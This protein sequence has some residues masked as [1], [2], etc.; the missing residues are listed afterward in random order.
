LPEPP[1]AAAQDFEATSFLETLQGFRKASR[2]AKKIPAS[3][4]I[5]TA[6]ELDVLLSRVAVDNSPEAWA[7]LFL[8]PHIAFDVLSPNSNPKKSLTSKLKRNLRSWREGTRKPQ[9]PKRLPPKS[10]NAAKL[11]QSNDARLARQVEGKMA[12]GDIR[13]AVRILSSSEGLAPFTQETFTALKTKHPPATT[14]MPPPSAPDIP[15]LQ[16][17]E[18]EVARTVA[19]FPAGSSGGPDGLRPQ[20]LK[21]LLSQNTGAAGTKLL[22]SLTEVTN[23]ILAGGVP[24]QVLPF[25]F[26]ANLVALEKKGGGIRPIAM[27]CTLRKLAAKIACESVRDHLGSQ[28]QPLQMGF[29]TTCGAE[30]SVHASRRFLSTCKSGLFLKLDFANAFNS[31]HR[32]RVLEATHQHLPSLFPLIQQ[33]Y[34]APSTLFFGQETLQSAEGLQQGDPLGSALFCLTIHDL[35]KS[36][37][38]HLNIWYADDGTLGG[39]GRFVLADLKTIQDASAELGLHLNPAKCELW[40]IG[41]DEQ[42]VVDSISELLPGI[43]IRAL[44]DC[45]LL[46]APLT[47]EAIPSAFMEKIEE[48]KRLTSRLPSLQAHSA[49]FLLKN[50]FSIPKLVYIL[51][52]CPSWKVQHLLNEFDKVTRSAL[53]IITNVSISD[54]TWAQ[55]SLPVSRGGLGIRSA[56]DL[57]VPAFLASI[58]STAY[59]VPSILSRTSHCPDPDHEEALWIWHRLT[60]YALIPNSNQQRDWEAPVLDRLT[61]SLL[62]AA[63]NPQ[64]KARLLATGRKESGAWLSALPCA[65]LGLALDNN[66]VRI[67]VGLRLGTSLCHPHKCVCGEPVD[68]LGTH[69]LSCIKKGGTF[70]RHFALN[71]IIQRA[72][73]K[74]HVPTLLEPTNMFRTDGKRADGLTLTPW[75]RGK[76]L[77]WDATCVDTLCKSYVPATAKNSGAAAARAEKKKTDLYAQLPSQYQFVP[78]AVETLGPIGEAAQKFIRELGGRLRATTGEP[79]ETTWL[80]QRISLAIQ[81]GNAASVLATIPPNSDYYQTYNL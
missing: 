51:R 41:V 10:K 60:D 6:T 64:E 66:A 49:L 79:R 17:D 58:A 70:S 39:P 44:E 67:A 62:E 23:L 69:G 1:P 2:I 8:F 65:P 63:Q 19:H 38:S 61:A 72:C 68:G 77:V 42:V 37:K 76:S 29:G 32:S 24:K 35:V 78:F 75:S 4:R 80:I 43:R 59:L 30:A 71:E 48:V 5:P 15:Y 53:E 81:R 31:T 16:V 73:S 54:S 56:G 22:G 50:C 11:V 12:E 28:L 47:P 52:C 26:G 46:G 9:P 21:D 55:A 25:I 34:S 7:D 18:K 3:V 36:L 57:S 14:T 33:A 40:V 74:V 27:G 20:H 13:G 45:M